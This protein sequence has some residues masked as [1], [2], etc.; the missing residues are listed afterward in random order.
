MMAKKR[1]D[2]VVS[3]SAAPKIL[4][5]SSSNVGGVCVQM[6]SLNLIV[7]QVCRRLRKGHVPKEITVITF[8][9]HRFSM[10]KFQRQFSMVIPRDPLPY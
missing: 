1:T 10:V 7:M 2:K 9:L 6:T 5:Y 8:Y 3:V 4:G